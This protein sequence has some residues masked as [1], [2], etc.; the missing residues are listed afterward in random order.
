MALLN[1]RRL[2][3]TTIRVGYQCK[4]LESLIQLELPPLPIQDFN[5]TPVGF[6]YQRKI[7]KAPSVT[8]FAGGVDTRDLR[9]CVVCGKSDRIDILVHRVHIIKRKE[10]LEQGLVSKKEF[11]CGLDY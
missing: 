1:L 4:Q 2:L 10:G 7:S 11:C 3:S 6:E 9:R 8:G 5:R